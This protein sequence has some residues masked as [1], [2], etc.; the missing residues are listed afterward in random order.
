[1]TLILSTVS[2]LGFWLAV[3][4]LKVP[5]HVQTSILCRMT[6]LLGT[7]WPRGL[8]IVGDLQKHPQL[9]VVQVKT[10]RKQGVEIML[11]LREPVRLRDLLAGIDGV[12]Q[13]L[14]D[15]TPGSSDSEAS[16][17]VLQ[18]RERVLSLQLAG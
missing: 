13:V 8:R 4:R 11:A 12:S 14:H 3:C 10:D 18:P 2:S 6:L 16:S 1:M 17:D 9:R 15:E 5:S 7:V